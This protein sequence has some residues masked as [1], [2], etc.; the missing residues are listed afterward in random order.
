VHT[1]GQL[2]SNQI[3]PVPWLNARGIFLGGCGG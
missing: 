2:Y 3:N 1:G